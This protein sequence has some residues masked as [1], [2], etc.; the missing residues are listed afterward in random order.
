MWVGALS[1][2]SLSSPPS[3]R[4]PVMKLSAV[5]AA[6]AALHA[7]CSTK[8]TTSLL[9]E[10]KAAWG[11]RQGRADRVKTLVSTG[12]YWKYD[13]TCDV[14]MPHQQRL[15]RRRPLCRLLLP[16]VAQSTC[17]FDPHL[18]RRDGPHESKHPDTAFTC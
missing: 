7:S 8:N 9:V 13:A 16:Q 6:H 4:P 17:T 11:S 1:H 12:V 14:G 18:Q 10:V 5:C 15:T 2:A 3:P